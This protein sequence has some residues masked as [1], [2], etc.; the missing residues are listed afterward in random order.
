MANEMITQLPTVTNSSLS[1]ILYAVTGYNPPSSNGTSVQET[2]QQILSL[3]TAG[4]NI[5]VAFTGGNLQISATGLAGIGWNHIT[6]TSTT[7]IVDAGYIADNGSQ[8]SL[9]L[10]ATATLGSII[11]VVGLGAGGWKITQNASQSIRL[12]GSVT[13]TGTGGSLA[14]AQGDSL[15]IV[16]T[17]ANTTWNVL[18]GPQSA[19]LTIV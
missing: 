17:V 15:T 18:G 11:Y 9:L 10:P 8:V 2:V 12:S 14:G 19:G 3:I 4:S 7:M 1:D 16:C 13:T 5:S 6:G